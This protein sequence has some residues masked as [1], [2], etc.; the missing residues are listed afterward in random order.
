MAEDEGRSRARYDEL[1]D[2][3]E[4]HYSRLVQQNNI[5]GGPNYLQLVNDARVGQLLPFHMLSIRVLLSLI[6]PKISSSKDM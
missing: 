4:E 1:L 6:R 5:L 3:V 2:M